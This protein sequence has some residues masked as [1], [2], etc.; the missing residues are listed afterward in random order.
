MC[1][2]VFAT[3]RAVAQNAI[4]KRF[5]QLDRNQDGK[6]TPDEFPASDL[7]HAGMVEQVVERGIMPPWFAAQAKPDGETGEAYTPWANDRSL[8]EAEKQELLVWIAG[9]KPEGDRR[10]APQPRQ[11]PEGWLIGEP[12]AVFQFSDPVPVKA[13]GVMPYQYVTVETN[14]PEDKWVQAIEV[15]PGDRGVVHQSSWGFSRTCTCAAKP[16][17]TRSPE[18]M[19]RRRCFWTSRVTTSTGNCCT[20]TWS[21]CR[22]SPSHP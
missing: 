6:V 5:D 13:T 1:L 17:S 16:A 19:G 2:L 22:W 12:D 14:L 21:R 3:R 20:A 7:A 9:G 11:F 15:Q 18:R 8:A 10:D 4:E